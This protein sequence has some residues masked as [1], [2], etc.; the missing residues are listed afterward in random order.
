VHVWGAGGGAGVGNTRQFRSPGGGGAFVSGRLTV[1]PG[2]TFQLVLGRG[3]NQVDTSRAAAGTGT[4]AGPAPDA[5]GG[6]GFGRQGGNIVTE[7]ADST[8]RAASGGG[9]S[10]IRFGGVDVVAAGGGGGGYGYTTVAGGGAGGVW[11]GASGDNMGILPVAGA[12]IIAAG[13][14]AGVGASY[15]SPGAAVPDAAFAAH[16]APSTARSCA[17]GV[18]F[19][20]CGNPWWWGGGGGGGSFGGSGGVDYGGGGGASAAF[21]L[22]SLVAEDGFRYLAG[23]QDDAFYEPGVGAGG[24]TAMPGAGPGANAF[25]ACSAEE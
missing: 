17:G 15:A 12:S 5:V 25:S 6:G 23:G 11:A 8:S 14:T 3:G 9:R 1:T 16:S 22:A 7:G 20:G 13:T 2:M 18:G 19:G 10:A 21:A 4:I 24:L